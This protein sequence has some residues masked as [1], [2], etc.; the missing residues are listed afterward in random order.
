MIIYIPIEIFVRELP[1]YILLAITA[2]SRGHQVMIA[3]PSD[4]W[5]YKRLGLLKKGCYLL[6]NMN[7]PMAS[8]DIYN[9]FIDDGFD[10]YCQEQEAGILWEKFDDYLKE[11]NITESQ[12][13]PFKGVFC[14]G[15]RDTFGYKSLF[16]KNQNIFFNTGSPRADIWNY[17][18]NEYHRRDKNTKLTPYILFVS[19]LSMLIGENH[20]SEWMVTLDSLELLLTDEHE[21]NWI[22]AVGDDLK[23]AISMILGIKFLANKYSNMKILLRPH[24]CDNVEYWKNIFNKNKNVQ[25]TNNIDSISPLISHAEVVIQNGCT[26]AMEAVLQGVPV[27]S[28]GPDR[29][30][31]KLSVPNKLGI[32]AR[33]NDELDAAILMI[34]NGN[35]TEHNKNKMILKPLINTEN[36]DSATAIVKIMESISKNNYDF[37]LNKRDGYKLIFARTLKNIIDN[38]RT[39]ISMNKYKTSV[40]QFNKKEIEKE[41]NTLSSIHGHQ[42]PNVLVLCKSGIIIS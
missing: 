30:Y 42:S 1:G 36:S 19:N 20:F 25:I 4:I 39:I 17:K 38:A 8:A 3:S 28:Y 32:R 26:S 31:S 40:Y 37:K 35:Y 10:L 11:I 16:K 22:K 15:E 6:K 21:A 24:P 7:V 18:Y 33:N 2:V 9:H 34:K 14:W 5:L 27:I 12:I 13:L 41:I 29:V 23:I